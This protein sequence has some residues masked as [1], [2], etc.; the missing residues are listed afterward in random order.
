MNRKDYLSKRKE[1][2]A[3][4]EKFTGWYSLSNIRRANTAALLVLLVWLSALFAGFAYAGTIGTC[5]FF[6]LIALALY[7]E[8]AK[9]RLLRQISDSADLKGGI[10]IA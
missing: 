1:Y 3:L 4:A 8:I 2:T 10:F 7:A 9:R 6:A 5:G